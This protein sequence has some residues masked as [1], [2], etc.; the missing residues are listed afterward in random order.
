[1]DALLMCGGRGTR[2]DRGEKPL[3]EVAGTPMVDRVLAALSASRV[4]AVTAVTSPHVPETT[5]HLQGRVP[6]V[7]TAGDGYV[8]DL[9]AA[10]QRVDRPVLTAVADL[11]LLAAGP[12]DRTLSAHEGG[13][14]TV[15]VP[16]ALKQ[17]LG[18]SADATGAT[19]RSEV[20]DS[21][22]GERAADRREAAG[23]ANGSGATRER[24]DP[25]AAERGDGAPGGRRLSPA[26]LNV[27]GIGDERLEVSYDARLAVN[28]NR[29]ADAEVAEV[30][31]D[32]PR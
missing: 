7:E 5:T 26:G 12:V 21:A 32:G 25:R 14:L 16:T 20:A 19:E 17:A 8:A 4:A 29:P 24:R 30:F 9:T 22:G 15:C 13:S 31:A 28:V 1:V 10:L 6:V 23:R 18:V 11:P 2:L 27:V 3:F